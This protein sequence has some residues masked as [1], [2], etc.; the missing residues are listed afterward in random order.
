MVGPDDLQLCMAYNNRGTVFYDMCRKKEALA[1]YE[2]A[3][4]IKERTLGR[5]HP[6]TQVTIENIDIIKEEL[7]NEPSAPR[8]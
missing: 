7:R 6:S 8:I 4:V 1:W 2:R 3:L 5:E